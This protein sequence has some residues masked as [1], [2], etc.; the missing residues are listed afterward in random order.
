MIYKLK[1]LS[2]KCCAA[3]PTWSLA[4]PITCRPNFMAPPKNLLLK[5]WFASNKQLLVICNTTSETTCIC[6]GKTN[7][8]INKVIKTWLY[9]RIN[10]RSI[11]KE[12]FKSSNAKAKSMRPWEK[13]LF[14][15]TL[16]KLSHASCSLKSLLRLSSWRTIW[17]RYR[18]HLR[19]FPSSI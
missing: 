9:S 12:C 19:T 8:W 3:N 6:L 7:S 1:Y 4:T 16:I 10:W 18:F 11:L 5:T 14:S 13:M 15:K 2:S 17:N